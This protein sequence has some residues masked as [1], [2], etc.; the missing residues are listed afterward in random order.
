MKVIEAL[1]DAVEGGA[2][3]QQVDELVKNFIQRLTC[4]VFYI[5][6]SLNNLNPRRYCTL[7]VLKNHFEQ[8]DTNHQSDGVAT[9][10]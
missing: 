10:A 7:P 4:L 5:N 9:D 3:D 1:A 2:R 6:V 8:T